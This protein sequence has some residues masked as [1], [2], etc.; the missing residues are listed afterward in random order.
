MESLF[1]ADLGC[2]ALFTEALNHVNSNLKPDI[3]YTRREIVLRGKGNSNIPVD[4]ESDPDITIGAL[5]RLVKDTPSAEQYCSKIKN[6][7]GSRCV[8]HF[9]AEFQIFRDKVRCFLVYFSYS[10]FPVTH[11]SH[12][13]I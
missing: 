4:F 5:Y 2:I 3:P 10:R 9:T 7:A 11:I 8:N 12:V 1:I 13:R 6:S